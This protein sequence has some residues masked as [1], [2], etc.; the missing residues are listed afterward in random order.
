MFDLK[1]MNSVLGELEEGS[2]ASQIDL[3]VRLHRPHER[4]LPGLSWTQ[5]EDGLLGPSDRFRNEAG[6]CN[7]VVILRCILTAINR[8]H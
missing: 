5:E 2:L 8:G 4:G 6:E 3:Q 1:V 7:H